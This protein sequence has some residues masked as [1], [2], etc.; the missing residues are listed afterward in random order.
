MR[1][2]TVAALLAITGAALALAQDAGAPPDPQAPPPT[3]PADIE[4]VIV[5]LVV[6]DGKGQPVRGLTRDDL[7]VSE[8][9]RASC[10]ERV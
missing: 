4:Q 9:G 6:V 1:R 10:R 2:E 3:F 8:D 5:D 7:I